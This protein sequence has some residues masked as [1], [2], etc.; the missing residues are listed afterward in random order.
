MA[1][2]A[3]AN[4]ESGN[5]AAS[6]VVVQRHWQ[7]TQEEVSACL[8]QGSLS[9]A[10]WSGE[11]L[12]LIEKGPD[13]SGRLSRV[14]ST[15]A[16]RKRRESTSSRSDGVWPE[17]SRSY[18]AGWM[19]VSM[20]EGF[21]IRR[22]SVEGFKGFTRPQE[23]DLMDRHTFLIGP[24]GNGKSSIIEAIRWGLF[25]SSNRPNDTIRNV[26]YPGDCRVQM[27]MSRDG[28]AWRLQ[29]VLIPG[30]GDS[31]AQLVDER[32]K[33]HRISDILPQ[34]D[35]ADAGE[36]THIIF[37]AQSAPLGRQ[38]EDL[39]PF[40]RTVIRHLGLTDARGLLSYLETFVAEQED[41]ESTLA[42]QVE[43]RRG[44]LDERIAA[45]ERQCDLILGSPPW[46]TDL[47]PSMAETE[48][49]ARELIREITSSDDEKEYEQFSLEALVDEV[50]RKLE[51]SVASSQTPLTER[52]AAVQEELTSLEAIG[53]AGDGLAKKREELRTAEE[54]LEGVLAGS[55]LEQLAEQVDEQRDLADALAHRHRLGKA[56]LALLE[57]REDDDVVPCPICDTDK[58][59]EELKRLVTAVVQSSSEEDSQEM[60]IAEGRLKA[61]RDAALCVE[62]VERETEAAAS[63]FDAMI[64]A[65]ENEEL[66]TAIRSGRLPDY[67]SS[68]QKRKQSLEG[69]IGSFEEWLT[70]VQGRLEKLRE[71]AR[72]QQ[73]QRE[74][75]ALKAVEAELGLAEQVF[76]QFVQFGESVG[77]VRDS[78]KS[79]L[80]EQLREKVPGVTEDLTVAFRALTEHRDFD[81]L[82]V[83]EEQ[84]PKLEL[85][86]ASS[87]D[88]SGTPYPTGVLNGQAQSALAL[89]PYFALGQSHGAPTEVYLVLLDDPTRAFDRDHIAILIERLAEL[90]RRVQV[91]VATQETGTFRELLPASFDRDSYVI[92]EP[93]DWSREDGPKLV[94]EYGKACGNGSC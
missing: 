67:V 24:N 1:G 11:G 59:R 77:D 55:S 83:D 27:D 26:R 74:L 7:Q 58:V 40:E 5:D 79:T 62:G 49:A 81:R 4:S 16:V 41:E 73:Y 28:T 42:E 25:G 12:R 60:R 54:A 57:Q 39:T 71:E 20:A 70:G 36:G 35:S 13:R 88:P 10:N 15:E 75:I 38:P 94:A 21:R 82:V 89:V 48:V 45:L 31:R 86:V 52:L 64:G 14:N 3:I 69:Q 91:V 43:E 56:A 9:S 33:E 80:I 23:I 32:G 92:V 65:R 44:Q 51:E 47:P 63:E 19:S 29:R 78:V 6:S 61:A 30:S 46:E 87:S 37:A 84:L 90:G 8:K 34:L 50:S 2:A 68:V 85:L 53:D 22:I 72:F 17:R 66:A 18:S 76:D 93:T